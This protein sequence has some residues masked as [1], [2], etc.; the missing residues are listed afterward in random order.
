MVSPT[1]A[2]VSKKL[3]GLLKAQLFVEPGVLDDLGSGQGK[4]LGA[5]FLVGGG[6]GV[7]AVRIVDVQDAADGT[8][9]TTKGTASSEQTFW[10]D[11]DVARMLGNIAATDGFTFEGD[12]AGDAFADAQLEFRGIDGEAAWRRGS[13]G[14]WWCGI[15]QD[16][17]AAG[18]VR[19][20]LHRLVED[21]LQRLLGPKRQRM[22][23][24]CRPGKAG[25]AGRNGP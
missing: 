21:E 13:R 2:S 10:R 16:D 4:G 23:D 25:R 8:V 14:R 24:V 22:N 17:R 11:L 20:F 1:R 5:R 12:P 6:E 15:D 9:V 7:L 19:D 3:R 18:S